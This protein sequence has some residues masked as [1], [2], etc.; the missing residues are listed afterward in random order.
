MKPFNNDDDL[1][2]A[3]FALELEEP[4]ADLR[5]GILNA[6]IYRA[7]VKVASWEV[8]AWGAFAAILVWLLVAAAQGRAAGLELLAQNAA[9]SL[10]PLA[11][12]DVLFWVAMG[13]SA[14]FWISQ[15]NLTIAPGA[16]RITRR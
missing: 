5:A 14:W 16:Q 10:E 8:A 1:D 3:L 9:Q 15:L 7:P 2:R 4:P 6:T 13:I 11:R 12:L